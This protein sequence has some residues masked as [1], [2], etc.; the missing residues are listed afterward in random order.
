[1]KIAPEQRALE[2]TLHAI[3]EAKKAGE[4]RLYFFTVGQD[5]VGFV[6]QIR[7]SKHVERVYYDSHGEYLRE[8]TKRSRKLKKDLERN[9]CSPM[10][11]YVASLKK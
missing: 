11:P 6:E 1:M 10:Q 8:V 3:K 7:A 9:G 4:E 5:E 2:Y